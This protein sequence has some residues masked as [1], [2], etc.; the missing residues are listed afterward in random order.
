MVKKKKVKSKS[1][2]K[3]IKIMKETVTP[4]KTMKLKATNGWTLWDLSYVKA[5]E[6]VEVEASYGQRLLEQT[7]N[8]KRV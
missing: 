1:E 2:E 3:R 7:S 4:P 8:F 5:G 6:I